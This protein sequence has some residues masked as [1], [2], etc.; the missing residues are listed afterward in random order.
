MDVG[1]PQ[2]AMHSAYE[3][4]AA[5]DADCLIRAMAAYFA[6]NLRIGPDGIT[7]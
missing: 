5:S 7:L 6:C 1:L 2:L 4:A 3:L